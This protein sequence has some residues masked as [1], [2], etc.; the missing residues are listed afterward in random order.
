MILGHLCNEGLGQQGAQYNSKILAIRLTV[1]KNFPGSHCCGSEME[2][3]DAGYFI[4]CYAMLQIQSFE[5]WYLS[6]WTGGDRN[7]YRLYI[8]IGAQTVQIAWPICALLGN[9][10]NLGSNKEIQL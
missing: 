4:H 2:K 10:G 8:F 3:K 6:L 9:L 5:L 1:T 7:K